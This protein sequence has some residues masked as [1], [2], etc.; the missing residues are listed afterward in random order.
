MTEEELRVLELTL[1]PVEI[2]N[3]HATPF[4]AGLMRTGISAAIRA[5]V[6]RDRAFLLRVLS[7]NE[8]DELQQKYVVRLVDAYRRWLIRDSASY[9]REVRRAL[10]RL[11][12]VRTTDAASAHAFAYSL[13]RWRNTNMYKQYACVVRFD[14]AGC[15]YAPYLSQC[16]PVHTQEATRLLSRTT[17][18][19]TITPWHLYVLWLELHYLDT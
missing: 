9:P 18:E 4:L 13:I 14:L 15:A 5:S 1:S 12:A 10:G 7:L 16:D 17:F 6:M 2:L 19:T 8:T 3:T 11:C